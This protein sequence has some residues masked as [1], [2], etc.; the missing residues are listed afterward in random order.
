[1][2]PLSEQSEQGLAR[3]QQW[4]R[5]ASFAVYYGQGQAEQLVKYDVCVVE[6]AGQCPGAVRALQRAGC[7]I[8]AYCSVMELLPFTALTLP[9]TAY[10]WQDDRRLTNPQFGGYLMDLRCD[11]WRRWLLHRAARLLSAGFDGLWLD[12]IADVEYPSWPALLQAQLLSAAAGLVRQLRQAWP[13]HLLVQNNGLRQLIRQ[14]GPNLDGVCWEHPSDE[15]SSSSG[16]L[17][18]LETNLQLTARRPGLRLLLLRSELGEAATPAR[19]SDWR[20]ATQQAGLLYYRAPRDYLRL[21]SS[22]PG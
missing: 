19:E 5:A 14:T 15:L 4:R 18:E 16:A 2:Q 9:A 7:L 1:M 22:P 11:H 3:R 20:R 8:L 10:L 12:T 13:A 21:T 17:T 6:P